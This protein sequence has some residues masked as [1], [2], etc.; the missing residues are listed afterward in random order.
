MSNTPNL[1]F[2]SEP[3]NTSLTPSHWADVVANRV[4]REKGDLECYTIASGISP[5][6]YVHFGNFR[7]VMTQELVA[8]G[9]QKL[10]K[11]VRFI[12]SWDEFDHLRKIPR[13]VPNSEE[14]AKYL[15]YPLV[16]VPDPW[17]ENISYAERFEKL[18]EAEIAQ[19]GIKPEF[20]YQASK[21]RSGTYKEDIV[22]ALKSAQTIREIL[23]KYRTTPLDDNWLPISIYCRKNGDDQ[24]NEI[25]WDGNLLV[26]YTHRT[27]YKD[28]LNLANLEDLALIKLPWRVDWPMRWAKENVSFESAGKDHSSEG[29]S[30]DT[31][32]IIIKDVWNKSAPTYMEYG[33]VG[34][35]GKG[36]KMSSSS[37]ENITLSTLLEVYEPHIIRWIYASYKP[38]VDFSIGLDED[39][40]RTYED[41]DRQERIAYGFEEANEKKK[42][43]VKKIY[44]L[45]SITFEAPEYMAYQPSFRHLTVNL[46]LA[47][48][49]VKICSKYY[50]DHLKT[51]YDEKK[52]YLR[53]QCALN[54]LAKYAPQ[55]Y[56]FSININRKDM[57][58]SDKELLFLKQ[59]KEILNNEWETFTTDIILHDTIYKVIHSLELPPNEAFKIMYQAL[60]S[61]DKGPRL[62]SFILNIGKDR[63]LSLI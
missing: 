18:F 28:T 25:T 50:I 34:L 31:G 39:V 53:A 32:K 9:L 27:G 33:F 23:N 14:L 52:F 3:Q 41:F 6:G 12:Y 19:L 47:D 16:D 13:N 36:G 59:L 54:W 20:I 35:K 56:L 38:N 49:D 40:I 21:Y 4:I 15:Y 42:A 2:E 63:V 11:Q 1:G 29:S 60:I 26:S 22:T 43:N 37:G 44:E 45:S 51:E 7:E 8:R 58:L 55:E 30:Y 24:V 46:Q 5:S 48:K 61:K 10:G 57:E 62:A 17:K